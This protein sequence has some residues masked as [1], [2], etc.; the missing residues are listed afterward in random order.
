M[1]IEIKSKNFL[2]NQPA[3][4]LIAEILTGA[5]DDFLGTKSSIDK[6]VVSDEENHGKEIEKIQIQYNKNIGY[7]NNKNHLAVA[8]TITSSDK[9]CSIVFL[10]LIFAGILVEKSKSNNLDDWDST[11]QLYYYL[12]FHELS[13]CYDDLNRIAIYNTQQFK[14]SEFS[15]NQIKEHYICTILSEFAACVRSNR[16][17]SQTVFFNEIKNTI[18]DCD[19]HLVA[20][21][22]QKKQ[23]LKTKI[24]IVDI[25]YQATQTFWFILTQFSKLIGSALNIER[26]FSFEQLSELPQSQINI[27][28]ILLELEDVLKKLWEQYPT[29]LPEAV[30]PLDLIWEKI[31][32]N[33]GYV[34]D[35]DDE[36]SLLIKK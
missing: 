9:K 28:P 4:S 31:A 17:M 5:I 12:I 27:T 10:D 16:M 6:I 26:G 7:T 20:L 22:K 13:H 18:S 1:I 36:N 23:Y 35:G 29:W 33:N 3:K 25:A 11:V 2:N 21:K 30:E 8:K 32:K 19:N 14:R 24:G 34:F 15:K